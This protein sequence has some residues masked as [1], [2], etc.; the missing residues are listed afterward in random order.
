[1]EQIVKTFNDGSLT[2]FVK[3]GDKSI[4]AFAHEIGRHIGLKTRA[5]NMQVQ[6]M[7]PSWKD[8][9]KNATSST[10]QKSTII[11]ES[12]MYWLVMRSNKKEAV[13]FRKWICEDVLPSIRKTGS[14]DL[15]RN[16]LVD[17]EQ[18]IVLQKR[19]FDF[20]IGEQKRDFEQREKRQ[21]V[22]H[23]KEDIEL[24][25]KYGI[26]D[27]KLQNI[28]K[29][30]MR[31]IIMGEDLLLLTDGEKAMPQLRLKRSVRAYIQHY[32]RTN[33]NLPKKECQIGR[34][35]AFKFRERYAA[36]DYPQKRNGDLDIRLMYDDCLKKN[37]MYR[38]QG[39]MGDN[40]SV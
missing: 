24:L 17:V 5:V 15:K 7:N 39:L 23:L 34:K 33:K 30:T 13:V 25:D 18:Q 14:Y 9:K 19:L 11:S 2:F 21:K 22:L 29:N 27:P 16:K 36:D 35:V 8:S 4:W 40:N 10:G 1:M 38:E 37:F 12:G 28:K 20:E 32:Y 3:E 6:K 26:N 31:E